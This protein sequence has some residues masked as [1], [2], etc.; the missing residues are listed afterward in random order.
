MPL[1]IPAARGFLQCFR[2]SS[3]QVF[4]AALWG[5]LSRME[6]LADCLA[7]EGVQIQH[8]PWLADCLI[9]SKTGG[10]EGLTAFQK[11]LFYIQDPAS[12][13]AVLALVDR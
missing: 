9:L 5:I 6:E 13:L 7:G 12:K 2:V 11:G 4:T 3:T 10:L 1:T 8:H